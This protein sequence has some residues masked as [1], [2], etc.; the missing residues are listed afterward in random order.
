MS[1]KASCCFSNFTE[2]LVSPVTKVESTH[3]DLCQQ[4]SPRCEDYMIKVECFYQCSPHAVHWMNPNYPAGFLHVPICESFCDSWFDACKDDLTCAKNW[5]NDFKWDSDGNH[6]QQDCVPFS[7]MYAN[8]TDLCQS[9]WGSS[10]MPSSSEGRC[11]EMDNQENTVV[12]QILCPSSRSHRTNFSHGKPCH[13]SALSPDQISP[14]ADIPSLME[15]L[16]DL[17][18]TGL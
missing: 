1:V 18:N 4:L 7:E 11:L 3:W 17:I 5:L 9:M 12:S 13:R 14:D 2:E 16:D 8:G 15:H 10:F 6:C